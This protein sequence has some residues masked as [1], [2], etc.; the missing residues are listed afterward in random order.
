[1]KKYY[2]ILIFVL[3]YSSISSAEIFKSPDIVI[4]SKLD[5]DWSQM[6]VGKLRTLLKNY[7]MADPFKGEFPGAI[8]LNESKLGPLLPQD[9]INLIRDFGNVVGL[10]FLETDTKVVMKDFSYEVR[11]FKTDIKANEKLNDGLSIGT[12]FSASEVSLKASKLSLSLVIPGVKSSPVFSVDVINPS[13]KA[14]EERLINFFAQIKIVDNKDHFKLKILKANFDQ[15]AN[16]LMSNTDDISLEYEKIVVPK[17]SVKIGDKTVN[18]SPE[19]IQKLIRDNH[20]AIKGILLSQAADFLKSNTSAAAF[21]VLEQ[22]QLTKEYW[23]ATSALESQ[24]RLENFGT[25]K[26]GDNIEVNMPGDFCTV[27]KFD[28]HKKDCISKKTTQTAPTRLNN[29]LHKNSVQEMKHLMADGDANIVASISEDYVNKLLVTTYDAG[30]WKDSLSQAGV[31]LG[32]NK[33]VM[34]LDKKGDSGTLIMD[35]IYTPTKMERFLTGSRVIRFPLVL[36]VSL[37]IEKHQEEP[38]VIIRLKDVDTSDDTIINGKPELNMVSSVK[39]VPRFKGK[40]AKAIRDKVSI[41]RNKDIIELR[42]PE[43]KGLGLDK[44]EFL[45]DGLGRMNAIM[46]LEDLIEDESGV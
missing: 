34:R 3:V 32:P 6:L 10:Q 17:V 19:K 8:T 36:D 18:F 7:N 2:S 37:R 21:K 11:G 22:Y 35:V 14:I 20:Q 1:M 38:V 44:V 29:L 42:Y 24:F 16:R 39:D 40:V 46:R 33:V 12:D 30:L 9:S 4:D 26:E 27:E 43:F 15:M 45:S 28:L 25:S 41:L 13:I 5:Y 23:I 31:E